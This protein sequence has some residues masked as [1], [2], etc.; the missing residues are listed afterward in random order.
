[1]PARPVDGLLRALRAVPEVAPVVTLMHCPKGMARR[2]AKVFAGVMQD[3]FT[4]IDRRESNDELEAKARTLRLVSLLVL[5]AP[6]NEPDTVDGAGANNRT[7]KEV[8]RRIQWAEAGRWNDLAAELA[9]RCADIAALP[10]RGTAAQTSSEPRVLEQA[11]AK[12]RGNCCRAA[13]QLLARPPPLPP[14]EATATATLKLFKTA[15]PVLAPGLRDA[16]APPADDAPTMVLRPRKVIDRIH[17]MRSGAQPGGSG[18]RPGHIKSLLLAPN[19]AELALQWC[20]RWIECAL[21]T[22][23]VGPFLSL[24]ARPLDKGEGKVRPIV[25]GEVLVKMAMGAAIDEVRDRL[26]DLFTAEVPD[27]AGRGLMVQLGMAQADGVG[28]FLQHAKFLQRAYPWR[29]L[30]TMDVKNAYGE[31]SRAWCRTAAAEAIPELDRPLAQ[32]WS[33]GGHRLWTERSPGSWHCTE[34]TDGLWQ[35]SSEA[36]AVFGLGQRKALINALR[37]LKAMDI[38]IDVAAYV[39]DAILSVSPEDFPQVWACI[40]RHL[41][42]AGLALVPHKCHAFIPGAS[43]V[44]TRV[45]ELVAQRF[46]GL[47][48]LGTAM[49]GE[50]EAFLGPYSLAL[51]PALLRVQRAERLAERVRALATASLRCP[52]VQP[53]WLLLSVVI[54]HALDFD[55]R[56]HP[57]D[58]MRPFVERLIQCVHQTLAVV[59]GLAQLAPELLEVVHLRANLGGLGVAHP[60]MAA[61]AAHIYAAMQTRPPV[62]KRLEALGWSQFAVRE[63]LPA[64][65]EFQALTD[66]AGQGVLIDA[67]GCPVEI[68][69]VRPYVDPTTCGRRP[70]DGPITSGS[71]PYDDPTTCGRSPYD[72]PT[73]QGRSGL[74]FNALPA[75]RDGACSDALAII[76]QHKQ[77]AILA[78]LSQRGKARLRSAGGDE[79]GLFLQAVPDSTS[80]IFADTEFRRAMWWRIGLPQAEAGTLCKLQAAGA[81]ARPCGCA[82]TGDADHAVTCKRGR[83][84]QRMHDVVAALTC[85]ACRDAGLEARR[86]IVVPAWARWKAPAGGGPEVCVEARMDVVTWS[87]GAV[88]RDLF[89]DGTVRHAVSNRYR[90]RAAREDGAATLLAAQEK[91]RRYPVVGGMRC[92]AAAVETLGRLGV[93]F[94]EL[95]QELAQLAA[96]HSEERGLPATR[97]SRKWRVELSCQLHKAVAR[98]VHE[99]VIGLGV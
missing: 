74:D 35:G 61:P 25:L 76:H 88:V 93:E 82:I 46:D 78:G 7:R 64:E 77:K 5:A 19:G 34:V 4:S 96:A 2:F 29:A 57:P 75:M 86:E 51:E 43:T 53:A 22:P 20:R 90:A 62:Y 47:P 44:D 50:F 94:L 70:Y 79:A 16:A 3:V 99:A 6:E 31:A 89:V 24:V 91:Q 63:F 26:D 39:D 85:Q 73:T 68:T 18:M 36:T 33:N 15:P 9:G 14:S 58:A 67:Q 69:A 27:L 55:I 52:S 38:R 95:L 41:A 40:G 42:Q 32:L 81:E 72:E 23:V 97:W 21:P 54:G 66:L 17:R 12:V 98:S 56:I 30:V 65:S 80:K 87:P 71:R 37:E 83:G 59:L 11:C 48:L 1:V 45:N 60:G 8:R 28:Q 10:D 13:A 92:T 49:Q 84:I